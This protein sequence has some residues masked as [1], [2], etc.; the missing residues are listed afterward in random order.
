[1]NAIDCQARFEKFDQ[2]NPVIY[3]V[4]LRFTQ[5]LKRLG[6]KGYS[7]RSIVHRIRWELDT[8]DAG[9]RRGTRI[10]NRWSVYYARKLIAEHPEFVGFFNFRNGKKAVD[11]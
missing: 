6:Y 5:Q 11:L 4:F 2:A 3:Q 8:G 7:A 10:D 9:D 1:M